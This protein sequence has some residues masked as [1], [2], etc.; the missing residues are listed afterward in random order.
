MD[1]LAETFLREEIFVKGLTSGASQVN[2]VI[3]QTKKKKLFSVT[4]GGDKRST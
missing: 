1:S 3:Y 2:P 4:A